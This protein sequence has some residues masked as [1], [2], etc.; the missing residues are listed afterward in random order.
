MSLT[1]HKRQIHKGERLA[2][3]IPSLVGGGA[4]RVTVN[5]ANGMAEKGVQ[6]DLVVADARGPYLEQVSKKVRVLDLG[7]SRVLTSLPSLIQYLRRDKPKALISALNHANVMALIA[8]QLSGVKTKIIVVEHSSL[9]FLKHSSEDVKRK[10]A[11][12]FR[13]V[14]F[15]YRFADLIVG[16]S[17]RVVDD[18]REYTR[19]SRDK[20]RVIY[21][22]VISEEMLQ[23][24]EEKLTDEWFAEGEPPVILAAGR[25]EE[26]KDFAT[27]IKAFAKLRSHMDA[28]L[29]ILGEGSKRPELE[30]LAKHLDLAEDIRLPGFVSNPYPYMKHA[31]LFVLS[32][33]YEGLPTVLIE[34]LSLG[35]PVVSTDCVSGPSEILQGGKH[36]AL[37]PIQDAPSLAKAMLNTLIMPGKRVERSALYPFTK[38]AAINAYLEAAEMPLN[39]ERTIR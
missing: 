20:F 7:A 19:L 13:S 30:A 35:T 9:D 6:V 29:M 1:V 15:F 11:M 27:L 36:G 39:Q 5:L 17:K 38:E 33:L 25:L 32:S 37:V 4:E 34:A 31:H 18:I 28:R 16:V 23:K 2:L 22:P 12:T 8:R 21:N 10:S 14:Q 24:A 3:Y 26:E